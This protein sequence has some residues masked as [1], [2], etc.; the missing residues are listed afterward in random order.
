M[1]DHATGQPVVCR[2]SACVSVLGR[3]VLGARLRLATVGGGGGVEESAERG[4]HLLGV[5]EPGLLGDRLQSLWRLQQQPAGP[6]QPGAR[7]FLL[8]RAPDGLFEPALELPGREMGLRDHRGDGQRLVAVLTDETHGPAHDRVGHG[9]DVGGPPGHDAARRDEHRFRRWFGAAHQAIQQR[10]GAVADLPAVGVHARQGR[11]G[12]S[13]E[14]F[15]VVHAEDGEL[16]GHA[17]A[18]LPAGGEDGGG[19]LIV[20]DEHAGGD[21]QGGEPAGQPAG[22]VEVEL[23]ASVAEGAEAFLEAAPAGGGRGRGGATVGETGQAAA[24]QVFGGESPD[25]FVVRQDRRAAQPGVLAGGDDDRQLAAIEQRTPFATDGAED[26]AVA[27]PSGGI[28]DDGQAAEGLGERNQPRAMPMGVFDH[29]DE[30]LAAVAVEGVEDD[31][32]AGR[33]AMSHMRQ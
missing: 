1:R 13:G 2:L 5:A 28:G 21:R 23:P 25:G 24:G 4:T 19:A 20:E 17:P 31:Q 33:R 26:N 3:G 27:R 30:G 18:R 12:Q 10:G 9:E 6:I 22:L 8:Q 16:V 32:H 11:I 29:A 15:V 7:Q 14:E